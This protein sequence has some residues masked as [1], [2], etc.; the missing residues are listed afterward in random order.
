MNELEQKLS[1]QPLRR[2]PAEWRA[3]ILAAAELPPRPA[4]R[5]SFLSG[6]NQQLS[7]WLWPH[8]KAWAGL[9]AVWVLIFAVDFSARD[10]RQPVA[11]KSAPPSLETVAEVRRQKLLFAQL[12]GPDEALVAKPLESFLPRPRSEREKLGDVKNL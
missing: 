11:E 2:I 5:A 4:P 9:A 7:M 3:E 10:W 12:M 1:R 8:P 6:L